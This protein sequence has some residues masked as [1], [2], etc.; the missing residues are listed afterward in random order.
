MSSK[1]GS[2]ENTNGVS[3]AEQWDHKNGDHVPVRGQETAAKPGNT[4]LA[5]YEKK[6]RAAA[7]TG[8]EKAKVAAAVSAQKVKVG[9]TTGI[10]WVK[11]QYQ[12]RTKK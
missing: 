5:E 12:K 11:D 7:S 2:A 3:W 6:M 9:T 4:K 10:K 1:K 8:Y